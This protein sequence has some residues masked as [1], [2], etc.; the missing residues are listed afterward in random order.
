VKRR[1]LAC[2][3]LELDRLNAAEKYVRALNVK[4][5]IA[6]NGNQDWLHAISALQGALLVKQGN[7]GAGLPQLKSALEAL[8]LDESNTKDRFYIFCQQLLQDALAE[9]R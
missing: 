3:S 4:T 8:A 7:P 1:F 5:L 2:V 9:R 6:A